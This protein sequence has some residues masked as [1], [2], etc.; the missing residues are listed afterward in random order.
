MNNDRPKV[1][2]AMWII[3]GVMPTP[4]WRTDDKSRPSASPTLYRR[5]LQ[6]CAIAA[7]TSEVDACRL[8]SDQPLLSERSEVDVECLRCFKGTAVYQ[9]FK[10]PGEMYTMT[11]YGLH[12]LHV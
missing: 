1:G 12:V 2:C 3:C 4:C 10:R 6:V 8:I 11:G 7:S 5:L 9:F